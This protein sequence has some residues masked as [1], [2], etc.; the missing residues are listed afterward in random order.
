VKSQEYEYHKT[1]TEFLGI[2][3]MSEDDKIDPSK[4]ST[5]EQ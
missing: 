3:V 5:V 1:I 2:L 4:V